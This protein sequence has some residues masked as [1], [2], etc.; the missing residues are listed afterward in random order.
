MSGWGEKE[1]ACTYARRLFT[2]IKEFGKCSG[3]KINES[4]S[5]GMWLG[6][7]KN[8]NRKPFNI[9]GPSTIKLL[10]VHVGYDVKVLEEKN[11]R[12]KINKVKQKMNIWKQR[13]L[14]IY[15][16]NINY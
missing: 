4:K 10:R 2:L 6:T 11:F 5:E 3:L 16:K 9:K 14:T 15:G 12:G 8:C 13:D 7:K 1:K